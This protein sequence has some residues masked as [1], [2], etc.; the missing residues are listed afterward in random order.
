MINQHPTT[1]GIL[2]RPEIQNIKNDLGSLKS[3]GSELLKEI[4]HEGAD[5][6]HDELDKLK[7][8]GKEK[9]RMAE[10]HVKSKP[11]Q[12]IAIAFASGLALSYLLA[13]RKH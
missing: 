13:R 12:G 7:Q 1:E 5:I 9:I 10:D 4:G 6:V 8:S 3:N 11:A 2:N